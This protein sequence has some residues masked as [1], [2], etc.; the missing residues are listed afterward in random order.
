MVQCCVG[1]HKYNESI[2]IQWFPKVS[3]ELFFCI[4]NARLP[5]SGS[6]GFVSQK[7]ASLNHCGTYLL[8]F[9]FFS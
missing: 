5:D 9:F 2:V 6:R 7:N 1:P 8:F 3:P 4:M